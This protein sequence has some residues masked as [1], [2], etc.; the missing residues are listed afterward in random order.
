MGAKIFEKHVG[1]KTKK[2]ELNK[3]STD[4]HQ[5]DKWLYH[6]YQ[7]V[8]M[9]GSVSG[10]NKNIKSELSQLNNFK[11]GVYFKKN[12]KFVKNSFLN[13]KNLSINFPAKSGQLTANELSKF[14]K[15]KEKR[16]LTIRSLCFEKKLKD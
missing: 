7:S 5:M 4:L 3:Y 14:S 13:L 9:M 6:L 12:R 10:R 8:I 16:I 2:I 11:R 1:L 15:F